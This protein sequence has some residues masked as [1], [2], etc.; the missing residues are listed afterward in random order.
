VHPEFEKIAFE[1]KLF[2]V[3]F[4]VPDYD[5]GDESP[6][7]FVVV[8]EIVQLDHDYGENIDQ[9]SNIRERINHLKISPLD[10][11]PLVAGNQIQSEI[12]FFAPNPR[13]SI[14]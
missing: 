4:L 12:R 6:S 10:L 1:V 8:I 2:S 7:H 9:T 5:L 14:L 13:I 3:E 11:N